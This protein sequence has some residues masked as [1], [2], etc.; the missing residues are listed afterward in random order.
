MLITRV[1]NRGGFK[2]REISSWMELISG[3][4]TGVRFTGV[5]DDPVS[6]GQLRS[7]TICGAYRP[8]EGDGGGGGVKN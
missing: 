4:Q 5:C 7:E 1:C 6:A 3:K 2:Q 8:G